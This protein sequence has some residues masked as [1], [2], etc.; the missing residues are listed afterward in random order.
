MQQEVASRMMFMKLFRF[1]SGNNYGGM[2]I[3]MTAPVLT[4]MDVPRCPSCASNQVMFFMLPGV[5]QSNPPYPMDPSVYLVTMPAMDVYVKYFGGW[6]TMFDKLMKVSDLQNELS[7]D[8]HSFIPSSFIM[9]GYDSPMKRSNRHNEVWFQAA[10]AETMSRIFHSVNVSSICA[11][12]ALRLGNQRDAGDLFVAVAKTEWGTIPGKANEKGCW[13]SYGGK[14]YFIKDPNDFVWV[15]C[16]RPVKLVKNEG[17]PPEFA[18]V[19]GYQDNYGYLYP[20]IAEDENLGR[21]PG[22]ARG[23]MCWYPYGGREMATKNFYW[24]DYE[25]R[26]YPPSKWVGTNTTVSHNGLFHSLLFGKLFAYISGNNAKQQK[27]EMTAPVLTKVIPRGTTTTYA[28]HFMIP[29]D[30]QNEPIAPADPSVYLVD[31]PA[32]DV[33][34]KAF[35]G[36]AID[37]VNIAEVDKLHQEIRDETK[38]E[39]SFYFTAGYDSPY[40]FLNRH[41]EVWL[42]ATG[43]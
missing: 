36:Y 17:K 23:D 25:L 32:L 26:H 3:E 14:E 22:K 2:K 40:T 37:R 12:N 27:I 15:T 34:V 20:A 42:V 38:F 18:I 35:G 16:D 39:N 30:L 28:M 8:S 7:R 6:P 33:Y 41:N 10:V 9:A 43:V 4:K 19:C 21:I 31:L 5:H 24:I 29:F 13:Y 11:H 1:I